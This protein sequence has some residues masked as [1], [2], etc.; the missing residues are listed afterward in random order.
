MFFRLTNKSDTESTKRVSEQANNM[1]R[2]K[3]RVEINKDYLIKH[4]T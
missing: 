4:K 1:Q 3:W 2:Y